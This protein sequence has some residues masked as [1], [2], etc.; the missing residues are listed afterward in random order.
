MVSTL[1]EPGASVSSALRRRDPAHQLEVGDGDWTVLRASAH[2]ADTP[3][4]LRGARGRGVPVDV[5]AQVAFDRPAPPAAGQDGGAERE[6]LYGRPMR[7]AARAPAPDAH[8]AYADD[9][10]ALVP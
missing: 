3:R 10:G 7:N 8:G 6:A 5:P 2:R 9:V 4:H 1:R